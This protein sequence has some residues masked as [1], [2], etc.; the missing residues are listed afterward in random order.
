MSLLSRLSVKGKLLLMITVPLIALVYLLAEDVSVRS[1]QKSEMQAI[2]VLVNL[3]RQNSLLAHELQKERGLSAGFLGSQGTSFSETLPQQRRVS[4]DQL[5][6]WEVLLDH[7]DLSDYPKVAAVITTA[8]A[9]LQRLADVRSGVAGLAL[10]L[11]DALAFYTGIIRHLLALSA[12]ATD[13][14]SDGAISRQLQAYYNLLQGKERAGIERA[15]LSNAFGAN[16]FSAGLYLRFIRLETE[17]S[18]YLDSFYQFSNAAGRQ[19]FDAFLGSAFQRAVADYRAMAHQYATTGGFGVA[20]SDWFAASTARINQ[21]KVLENGLE[22]VLLDT[23]S[24]RL[25]DVSRAYWNIILLGLFFLILSTVLTL[26]VSGMFYRQVKV[27][28]QQIVAISQGL[29]LS[30][31]V[32]VYLKDELGEVATACNQLL[33]RMEETVSQIAISA[34]EMNLIAI[35]N[36]MTIS[37]STRGMQ[38]QQDET[39][40]A[41]TAVSQLEQAT[42]DIAYSIQQVADQASQAN[43]TA[44]SSG[45]TVDLSLGC[46]ENLN[47]QMNQAAEVIQD[48]HRS[49][50]AIAGVLEVIKAIA[51][52]TNLLAL[53]AAIEAARAGE[54]GR[55]FAVVA[56]EVR[57]LAQKTQES[58]AEIGRIVGRFQQDSQLAYHSVEESQKVAR[59][60]VEL[61]GTVARELAQIRS[62]VRSIRDMSDQVAAAAEEQVTTNKELGQNMMAIQRSSEST[63]ATGK[64]MRKTGGQQ[65]ELAGNLMTLAERF[66]LHQD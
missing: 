7:T 58:T 10:D 63:V 61:S 27:L 32:P 2:S 30:Q 15:V 44:D 60:T 12:I 24:S 28:H 55:G 41:A 3:A 62:A 22:A 18:A 5:Q 6:A 52:Q 25:A 26:L 37:L 23:A 39:S 54:Q 48:L 11:P 36:H 57:S 56:D 40:S 19:Q 14:T 9:D 4:D 59:Q 34:T 16:E 46:I 29:D 53:N 65:R 43:Q 45:E 13:Y 49:S 51:E 20:A 38:V 42:Q 33:E 35:Q 64:F 47:T 50:D 31:R 66:R 17:Q 1:V 21:L 8:Q